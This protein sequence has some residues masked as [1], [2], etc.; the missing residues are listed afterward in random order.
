MNPRE[1]DTLIIGGGI[2]GLS[3]AWRLARTG[4]RVI[5]LERGSAGGEASRMA[6]G[7]LAA[8]AEV[9]YEEFDLYALCTDAVRRWPSFA[10][11]LEE[12]SGISVD[13]RSQGTMVAARDPD[14]A[15]ALRRAFEFQQEH[16]FEVSWLTRAEALDRE[17]FLSPRIAA[18]VYAADDHSV[19]NRA[20]TRALVAAIRALGGRVE[21]ET[22]VTD[23]LMDTQG[24]DHRVHTAPGNADWSAGQIVLA[25]GAWSHD[26]A[27]LPEVARPPVRPVKGQILTLRMEAPFRLEHV[28]RGTRA[29]LV[30]RTNG[31]LVVG[32]TS[33]EMGFNTELTA[34]GLWSV[35]DG[36]WELVPGILDLPVMETSVGLR[37]G[38]R[39]HQPIVGWSDVPG[40]F[41]A[42][43]H[44]RHGVVLSSSTADAAANVLLGGDMP[45][46]MHPFSPTRFRVEA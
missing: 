40:L 38:S 20:V 12:D 23:V 22:E 42:T 39:D 5:V 28:V 35:L 44:Y 14:A 34:G 21:E 37:P 16:G 26:L 43:G 3:I 15:S 32:A 29:Y 2:I 9:G 18:A 13:F 45:A 11:E 17:P 33:E 36:A 4:H 46:I 30:P 41:V 8:T 19:D 10:S 6:A 27:G 31:R 7:M 24:G 25:A 1:S